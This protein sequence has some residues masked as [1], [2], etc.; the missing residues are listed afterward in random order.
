MLP[1]KE[2]SWACAMSKERRLKTIERSD[3]KARL[4]ILERD[5]GLFRFEGEAEQEEDGYVFWAP[6]DISG[7]YQTADAAE[8]DARRMIPW[9]RNQTSS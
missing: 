9:L 8:Q 7:L 5:D 4:F 1:L 3:G 2:V 6:C